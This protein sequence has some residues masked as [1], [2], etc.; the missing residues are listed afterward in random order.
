MLVRP[1]AKNTRKTVYGFLINFFIRKEG[2]LIFASEFRN[3]AKI[4][5]K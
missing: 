1:N 2:T 3:T 4:N 5:G